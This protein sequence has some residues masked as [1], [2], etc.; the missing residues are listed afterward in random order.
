MLNEVFLPDPVLIN[1]VGHTAGLLLF[2]VIIVLLVRDGRAHGMQQIKLSLIAA[3]LALGWNAGALI[4]LASPN[5]GSFPVRTVTTA[6]FTLLSFL[7]AVLLQVALQ[8]QRRLIVWLGYA[9][10]LCAASLHFADLLVLD[11]RLHQTALIVIATG[12]DCL[13]IIAFVLSRSRNTD[14][15]MSASDWISFA[16]LTLFSSSFLHFGYQHG[17]S[18]WAAEIGWH[19]IGIPVALI[20]ILQDYR[21]LLLDAFVRFLVNAVS[22]AVYLALLLVLNRRFQITQ[23]AHGSM[24][25][26]GL[27]L[28]ALCLSLTL[29][30]YFRNIL[31]AWLGRAIFRRQSIADCVNAIANLAS[32]AQ[33]EED[34]IA[35]AAGEVALY[36]RTDRCAV[37]NERKGL[38][39]PEK[40]AVLFPEHADDSNPTVRFSAEAQIP[41]RFSSGDARY[42]IAGARQGGRRYLSE[43]LDDMRRLGAVIVEQVER[44]RAEELSRLVNQAELRALQAQINP[45]FLFNALNTLYGIID[46]T[47][48]DARRMV[49]NLSDIFRYFLQ[50]DRTVIALSEELRIVQAYLEIESL[51]LGDRLRTELSVSESARSAMIPIL[52]IQPLVENAVKHGVAAQAGPGRVSVLAEKTDEGVRITVADTGPGFEQSRGNSQGGTGVGLENVRR[53]LTLCYG[54]AASLAITSSSSGTTVTFLIPDQQTAGHP[55]LPAQALRGQ[56]TRQRSAVKDKPGPLAAHDPRYK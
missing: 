18:P 26:T 8:G 45:H 32:T 25:F 20:V 47:S 46:R 12:F 2:G 22:A 53:R 3:S 27:A 4:S 14:R 15:S 16:G 28:V 44:F 7:P 34:L 42:L 10:S 39:S 31:Q 37:L 9:V 13:T 36:L 33:S 24:F 30:A 21:F 38:Q 52:S 49:L 55:S 17:S 41:L 6:S 48:Y 5:P 29:F 54:P 35:K 43:D 40:P 1:T 19:H 56:G 50:G 23:S 11:S 51:R